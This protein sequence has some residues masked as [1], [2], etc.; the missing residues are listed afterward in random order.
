MAFILSIVIQIQ[1]EFRYDIKTGVFFIGT[2]FQGD[3]TRAALLSLSQNMQVCKMQR[4]N[5]ESAHV[6]TYMCKNHLWQYPDE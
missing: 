2:K 3:M 5:K 4:A 1:P 6:F